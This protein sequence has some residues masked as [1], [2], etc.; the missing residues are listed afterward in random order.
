MICAVL[1]P[2][3]KDGAALC[4]A[5]VCRIQ[6][7]AQDALEKEKLHCE[8]YTGE[9]GMHDAILADK[10]RS[11]SDHEHEELIVEQILDQITDSSKRLA[12]RLYMEEIPYDSGRRLPSIAKAVDKN[13]KT[14]RAW[15]KEI[16]AR[17]KRRW[18]HL[19]L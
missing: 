1:D 14:V 5:F 8:R 10:S 11:L 3:S 17:R 13:E 12:F 7:R 18:E 16:R 15:I 9:D 4:E 6:Y 19:H 2:K